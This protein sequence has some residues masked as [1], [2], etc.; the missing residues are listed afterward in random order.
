MAR[1]ADNKRASVFLGSCFKDEL[2][3]FLGLVQLLTH[4]EEIPQQYLGLH[5]IGIQFHGL[6]KAPY[7]PRGFFRLSS[8]LPSHR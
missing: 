1:E 2:D 4:Q 3:L 5:K 6:V 8:V 7:A